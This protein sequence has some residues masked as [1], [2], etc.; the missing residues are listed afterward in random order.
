[1]KWGYCF[2]ILCCCLCVRIPLATAE[3][4]SADFNQDKTVD[5]NDLILFQ[6]Q[7]HT[8]GANVP[9]TNPAE[10][11]NAEVTGVSIPGD[12]KPVVSFTLVDGN[13]DPIPPAS[14]YRF[15]FL[16]ARIVEDNLGQKRTH[17][18]NY[19]VNA[20]NW[21]TY[22]SGGAVTDLGNG[23]YT[24]KFTKV[25][26]IIGPNL[27]HTLGIQL[28][29][30]PDHDGKRSVVNP[31]FNFRPDGNPVTTVRELTDTKSCNQC[32]NPLA[33][34][35]GSRVEYGLCI[36]CHNPAVVGPTDT[37]QYEIDFARMIH[38]IH[39]SHT[40]QGFHN[41]ASATD[42]IN[43]A[44]HF[45]IGSADFSDI[46]FP[47]D[48]RNCQTCHTGSVD[49]SGEQAAYYKQ[50]PS[51][52]ACGGCHDKV[53]FATG[54]GHGVHE[55]P[56]QS[57]PPMT[58][59][60]LCSACHPANYTQ[61]LPDGEFDNSIPG[62]H[63]IPVKSVKLPTI[64]AKILGVAG[65]VPGGTPTVTFSLA[66]VIG[67]VTT[68]LAP[69]DLNRLAVTMA[70][71]TTDYE[72]ANTQTI[73]NGNSVDNM[74]GTRSFTFPSSAKIPVGFVGTL[75]FGMEARGNNITVDPNS[76]V[77]QTARAAAFNPVVYVAVS[78]AVEPRRQIVDENKCLKCHNVL[79]LHGANRNNTEY[80]V[81]CHNP[82][83][84][85][86]SRRNAD[87]MPPQ[88]IHFK[89]MIHRIHTGEDLNHDYTVFGFRTTP[90]SA[91]NPVN[92]NEVTFPGDRRDCEKCHLPGTWELPIVA[93]ATD[94]VVTQETGGV[95]EVIHLLPTQAACTA[96][97]DSDT[98]LGHVQTMIDLFDGTEKC[99]ECHGPS[100][101]W[102]VDK[103][104]YRGL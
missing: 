74:D 95:G 13:G 77:P 45:T 56:P 102:A 83:G 93:G 7:W 51:R 5:A 80:C 101:E 6:E 88:T 41:V 62:A 37:P 46:T 60:T 25:V 30:D 72:F 90:A 2:L 89:V 8:G 99:I 12:N 85:D 18:E 94:T 33:L 69:G 27:T 14:L 91:T 100:R 35:G 65:A 49:K 20:Q 86:E 64:V 21:P 19:L 78:K 40:F 17:Y 59:D 50:V 43:S 58:D 28:A 24:Y 31:L 98:A 81:F 92:F 67:G 79:S 11:A 36:L 26:N 38:Q 54:A 104:H 47:Q 96:C 84:D 9:S 66:S 61:D 15:R 3:V 70:G 53:D 1:M 4:P 68:T 55:N 39:I 34:H 73:T 87:D 76:A 63:T 52:R 29:Y 82:R 23:H 71:P 97:H 103:V 16:I 10:V 48:I 42:G 57:I 32:H 22:D 75:G 44:T